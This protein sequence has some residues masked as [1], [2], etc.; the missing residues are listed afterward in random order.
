MGSERFEI[1]TASTSSCT[2]AAADG[3]RVDAQT[4]V[5]HLHPGVP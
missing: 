1:P 3:V 2:T 5:D 4:E